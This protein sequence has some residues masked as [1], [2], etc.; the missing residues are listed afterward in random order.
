[1][2]WTDIFGGQTV[3]PQDVSY[4]SYSFSANT[5]LA[6]DNTTANADAVVTDIMDIATTAAGVT[7]TMPDARQAGAG[8]ALLVFNAGAETFTIAGN[9]GVTIQAVAPGEAWYIWLRDNSTQAGLWRAIE[10]GAG[11]SSASASALASETVKASG[12]TLV[13]AMPVFNINSNY[14]AGAGERGKLIRW[15]GGVGTLTLTLAATVG[16]DWFAAT[17]NAGSGALTIAPSGSDAIDGSTSSLVI[18]PGDSVILVSD[19]TGYYLA[20]KSLAPVNTFTYTSISVAGTGDFT[21]SSIQ[22]GFSLYE[23]TGTLTGNRNIIVPASVAPYRVINSTSG[24]YTLTVKTATGSGVSILQNGSKFLACDGSDV[25]DVV[26]LGIATPIAIADGGTGATTAS[27]AR[28]NLGATTVGNALF[29]A[30]DAPAARTTLGATAT[31][32]A[33]FTAASVAA[34][35]QALDV[36]VGVDVQAY[37]AGLASIAGLTTA[38]NQMLYLTA[39][40]T[41]SVTALT[42]AG[43]A[44]IDDA[45]AAAQR[46]TLGLGTIA[47]EA[48][49][50]FAADLVPD[51]DNTRDIGSQSNS[52][53]EGHFQSVHATNYKNPDGTKSVGADYV[54][55]G[56][57]KAW[58]NL[59]G[60]GTIALRDSFNVS[61]V[62]DNGT[63]SYNYNFTSAFATAN[64]SNSFSGDGAD[65]IISGSSASASKTASTLRQIT[66]NGIFAPADT[67]HASMTA[68]GN[69]A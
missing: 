28:T 42:A 23:F 47:T 54:V 56:T 22:L 7:I 34:A 10:F 48:S 19:G 68:C 58:A 30:A 64:Y 21:L 18:S 27:G 14:T 2:T 11:T 6:W 67:A 44:L 36:E 45:D 51:A 65:A 57:A 38:A 31:G 66:L 4:K 13:Q 59:N 9:T 39:S 52:W 17:N 50:S 55:E 61:S 16:G 40:D 26:S 25:V 1:M 5:T 60:T 43:R 12:A 37:D 49:G 69:L 29:T 53:Q 20:S 15:S 35:Q 32:N 63:G 41:Y 46:T 24:P 3:N 8:E 62:T 33:V